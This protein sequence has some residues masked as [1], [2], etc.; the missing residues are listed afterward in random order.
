MLKILFQLK[1]AACTII[2]EKKEGQTFFETIMLQMG[3]LDIDV[4]FILSFEI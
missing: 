3:I 4:Q 1:Q 2:C